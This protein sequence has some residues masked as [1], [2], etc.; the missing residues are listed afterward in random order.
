MPTT[1][2][3]AS[4]VINTARLAVPDAQSPKVTPPEPLEE[5]A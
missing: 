1:Q 2:E 5:G 3:T 4:D